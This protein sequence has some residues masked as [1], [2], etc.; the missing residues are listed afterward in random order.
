MSARKSA[1]AAP[2]FPDCSS[3]CNRGISPGG[4]AT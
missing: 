1:P 4:R 2:L 3:L